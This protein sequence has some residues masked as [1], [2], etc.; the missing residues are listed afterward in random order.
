MQ[1]QEAKENSLTKMQVFM[2]LGDII[3]LKTNGIIIYI[4]V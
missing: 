3:P 4:Q 2:L 1:L